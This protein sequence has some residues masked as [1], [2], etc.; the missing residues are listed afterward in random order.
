MANWLARLSVA[1]VAAA[2][3]VLSVPAVASA[4]PPTPIVPVPH[5]TGYGACL[6]R[7]EYTNL[8]SAPTTLDTIVTGQGYAIETVNITSDCSAA[9]DL[10]TTS[11]YAQLMTAYAVAGNTN[12][13]QWEVATYDAEDNP[14][15]TGC[16]ASGC[17]FY[18]VP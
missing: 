18:P 8:P 6:V 17:T 5:I 1:G 16:A 3:L 13:A 14:L 9:L 7:D 10:C 12:P 11:V 4:L 2:G 15:M